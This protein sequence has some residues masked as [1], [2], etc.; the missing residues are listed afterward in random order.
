MVDDDPDSIPGTDSFTQDELMV[1]F[2]QP[3][4]PKAHF[5]T[6]PIILNIP[7]VVVFTQLTLSCGYSRILWKNHFA[8]QDGFDKIDVDKTGTIS[9]SELTAALSKMANME[10]IGQR[11]IDLMAS[12]LME[13]VKMRNEGPYKDVITRR[14][15]VKALSAWCL[16]NAERRHNL[17]VAS[18]STPAQYF[19]VLRRQIHRDY[20]KPLVVMGAKWMLHHRH[21]V[22]SLLDMETGTY[23]RRI[24]VEGDD[25]DNMANKLK[26]P[27]LA[28]RDIKRVV[29]CT[30][31]MFYHLFHARNA[32]GIDDVKLVR[33]EQIAPFPYD[34]IMPC[35][36]RYPNAEVVWCQEEPK[37]M[38][39]Y[40]YV[41]A[42]LETSLRHIQV[43]TTVPVY[44]TP[45]LL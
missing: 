10:H 14:M 5:P 15:W 34:L 1:R 25:G 45:K 9:K 29:F 17:I 26:K 31:K 37:N 27:L 30:G 40:V 16:K 7:L 24:I 20:A 28:D 18:P 38:G 44:C 19:H 41:K 4:L 3:H 32:A 39:A 2:Y 42:R 43:H 13:D 36:M 35:L 21:C 11:E 12:E 8:I 23:F 22:S 33:I 6:N